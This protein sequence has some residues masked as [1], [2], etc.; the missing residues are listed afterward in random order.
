MNTHTHTYRIRERDT[1]THQQQKR[2]LIFNLSCTDALPVFVKP[3][4]T[5]SVVYSYHQGLCTLQS[6]WRGGVKLCVK[7]R[8]VWVYTL[9]CICVY[10]HTH[11]HTHTQTHTHTHTRT[12][13]HTHTHTH[14]DGQRQRHRDRDFSRYLFLTYIMTTEMMKHSDSSTQSSLWETGKTDWEN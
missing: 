10:T 11:T 2:V 13:A 9:S 12:H 3:P 6:I 1:H 4:C 14:T 8:I 7:L 5:P